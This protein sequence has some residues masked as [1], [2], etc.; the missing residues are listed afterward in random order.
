MSISV[1]SVTQVEVENSKTRVRANMGGVDKEE[2]NSA[3]HYES[4]WFEL[5]DVVL[6]KSSY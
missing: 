2:K 1:R 4:E 6:S 3:E 5:V